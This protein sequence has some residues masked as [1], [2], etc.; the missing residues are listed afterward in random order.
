VSDGTQSDPSADELRAAPRISLMLRSAKL[1]GPA[2]EFLCILRDVSATGIKAKLF[3]PLP[4]DQPLS[5]ELGSGERF[6]LEPVWQRDGHIGCR[7]ADGPVSLAALVEENGPFP[8]RQIRLRLEL[9][10]EL[11]VGQASLPG[12]LLD[13]SQHG[14]MVRLEAFL[15]LRQLVSIGGSS[16]PVR[17]AR[18]RWRRGSAH[19]LVFHE[20]FK[21]DE[22]ARLAGQL[23]S[24]CPA[25][26][27]AARVNH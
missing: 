19:G 14:A 8:K 18:V 4:A 11:T 10:V 21:L 23:Q 24:A 5:L 26:E 3:H 25:P 12:Q 27:N 2:G 20:G 16:L 7:F 6:A 1:V 9:P 15:A 13:L 17:H 22:L